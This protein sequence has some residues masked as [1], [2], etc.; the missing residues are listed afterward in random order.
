MSEAAVK[1][2]PSVSATSIGSAT[3]SSAPLFCKLVVWMCCIFSKYTLYSHDVIHLPF[4]SG[5]AGVTVGYKDFV[6]QV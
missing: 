2:P 1:E 3:I 4:L 5:F 6:E